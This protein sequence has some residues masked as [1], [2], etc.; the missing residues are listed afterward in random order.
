[1]H[2]EKNLVAH[3]LLVVVVVLTLKLY[4]MTACSDYRGWQDI[5]IKATTLASLTFISPSPASCVKKSS[6]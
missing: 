2:C 3:P 5:V 4:A 1:M 6:A